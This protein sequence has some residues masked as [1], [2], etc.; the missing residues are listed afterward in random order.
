MEYRIDREALAEFVAD[1]WRS[2]RRCRCRRLLRE[3]S[4]CGS[5][6][7]RSTRSEVRA[8]WLGGGA[9][10][11]CRAGDLRGAGAVHRRGRAGGAAGGLKR[12][13]E[14]MKTT[15]TPATRSTDARAPLWLGQRRRVGRRRARRRPGG[16]A[17][18]G[19]DGRGGRAGLDGRAAPARGASSSARTSARARAGAAPRR[20]R[21]QRH[22]ARCSA[23]SATATSRCRTGPRSRSATR[24]P[25]RGGRTGSARARR[26]AARGCTR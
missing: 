8:L 12:E 11:A 3:V 15:E 2:S 25:T 6:T 21:A 9:G 13:E 14:T 23:W 1:R 7:R 10:D 26:A 19:V 22:A 16:G 18:R 17:G 5:R 20:E 4:S 24:S